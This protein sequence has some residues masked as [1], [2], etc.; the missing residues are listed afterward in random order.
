MR[1]DQILWIDLLISDDI[2][3]VVFISAACKKNGMQPLCVLIIYTEFS[4]PVILV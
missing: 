1:Q 3:L 4:E 2:V